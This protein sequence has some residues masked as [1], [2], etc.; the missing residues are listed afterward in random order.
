[1]NKLNKGIYSWVACIWHHSS[2]HW[3]ING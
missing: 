3:W 1:M 2:L